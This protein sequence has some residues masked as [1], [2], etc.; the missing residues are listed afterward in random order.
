MQL[1]LV[2]DQH[3]GAVLA[4]GGQ[5]QAGKDEVQSQ[6]HRLEGFPSSLARDLSRKRK[7][8][9]RRQKDTDMLR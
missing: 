7:P 1:Q 8:K 2:L 6:S 3:C 9:L 4:V 5:N